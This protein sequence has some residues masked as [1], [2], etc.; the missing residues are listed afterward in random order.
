MAF[1]I[2][3]VTRDGDGGGVGSRV[4]RGAGGDDLAVGLAGDGEDL[5]VLS[6]EIGRGDAA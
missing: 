1:S 5:V 2:A 6:E 3:E 4:D